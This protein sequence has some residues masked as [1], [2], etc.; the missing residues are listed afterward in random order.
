[1]TLSTTAMMILI[2]S[3]LVTSIISGMTGMGG[4]TI[5]LAIIASL[6]DFS[7]V[8][9]LHGTV[10]LVSNSTRLILFFKNIKWN[11]IL[12]FSIGIIPGA[13]IGIHVFKLLDKNTVK[14]LMGIFILAI[15][16]FPKS[17][18][19]RKSSFALFLPVGLVSGL[20]G[21]FFGAIGPFIAPFFIRK[22][23]IK[24]EL[25]ATK[26]ACQSISH[27]LKIILFGYIGINVLEYWNI[28]LFLCIAVI[29]GTMLGKKFLNKISDKVFKKIFKIMLT[30]IALRIITLQLMKLTGL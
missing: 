15:T 8:V 30:V 12:F 3:A 21:I 26:A 20:I 14:L 9:P 10:Q 23:V 29:I 19:E 13:F 4:G 1:M 5:L 16:Y 24:E 11:I 7:Y 25:I 17:K 2:I 27:I 18:K 28:L 22:D 6:I